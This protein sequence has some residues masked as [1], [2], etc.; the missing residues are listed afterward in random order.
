MSGCVFNCKGVEMNQY[1]NEELILKV[2]NDP[3]A[4]EMERELANRL[5]EFLDREKQL[6]VSNGRN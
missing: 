6:G 3:K 4:T 1:S 2:D 5:Q